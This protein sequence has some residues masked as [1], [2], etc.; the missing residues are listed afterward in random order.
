MAGDPRI[1]TA[2]ANYNIDPGKGQLVQLTAA[3]KGGTDWY[4]AL[5]RVAPTTR[6]GFKSLAWK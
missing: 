2:L 3:N 1:A 4:K 5:T 6:L